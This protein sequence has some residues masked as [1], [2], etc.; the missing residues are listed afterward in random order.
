[1]SKKIDGKLFV[2][3]FKCVR[4]SNGFISPLTGEVVLWS[5]V[6]QIGGKGIDLLNK[7]L[8]E[9]LNEDVPTAK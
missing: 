5:V 1:M 3:D 7:K 6:E 9:Y 8:D 4:Q 2:P